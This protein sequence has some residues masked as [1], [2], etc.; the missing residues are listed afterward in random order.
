M[1]RF[2]NALQARGVRGLIGVMRQFKIIDSDN[3]GSLNLREF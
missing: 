2:R 3:S 1:G